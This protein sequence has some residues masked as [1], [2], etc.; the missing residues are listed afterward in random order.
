MTGMNRLKWVATLRA[1]GTPET[2]D[3]NNWCEGSD[4]GIPWVSIGDMSDGAEVTS[5]ARQVSQAGQVAK[6]LPIGERG[7]ILFGMYAS[8]GAVA[9]L[10][11]SSTWSQALL[12]ISPLHGRSHDGFLRYWLEHLRVDLGA[13]VRSNTQDNLNAEQVGNFPFPDLSSDEQ[14]AIADYL[15]TETQRIDQLIN[16]K[17][18]M[19]EVVFERRSVF[20]SQAV[21]RGVSDNSLVATT[22]PF[23]AEL[24]KHWR[25]MRLK[26]V[27]S[28]IVDTP[29]KTA[30][31][32]DEERFLVVRTSNVKLGH[33]VFSDARYTD[34]ASWREWNRRGE[35]KPGDI[36]FTREAPAGEACVVPDGQELCIGQRMVLI[37]I[38]PELVRSE[39][40]LH[41]IY[42]GSA[43]RFIEVLSNSTT[44]AHINMSDIP[45]L[46]VCLPTLEEQ[47]QILSAIQMEVRRSE[48]LIDR[49]NEQISLLVE[50]RVATI[51]AAVTGELEISGVV[52]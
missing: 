22:N 6:R 28:D 3:P 2:S 33:L 39:W 7:T 36:L 13:L 31:V 51:T 47:D 50:Q 34:E 19:I 10:G 43:Q 8:V 32:V 12:G 37:K 49:I 18:R 41:S 46:P 40:L 48:H 30:P 44:V 11:V 20:V 26:H 24:P 45:D 14:R 25:L 9:Q 4:S 16:K 23:V 17:R 21:T 52:A 15:D 27:V 42:S 1:G 35:P 29:H 5:T 38:A